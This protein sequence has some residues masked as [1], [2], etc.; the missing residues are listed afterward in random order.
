MHSLSQFERKLPEAKPAMASAD[1]TQHEDNPGSDC[2]PCHRD[3]PPIAPHISHDWA[4][5]LY[6]K[7]QPQ[8]PL[9][10]EGL[11]L[12]VWWYKSRH[13]NGN[14]NAIAQKTQM[15]S[16]HGPLVPEPVARGHEPKHHQGKLLG[17][18]C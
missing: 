6:T 5:Q 16:K 2:R 11:L 13:P 15:V 1:W 17:E 3:A 14:L 4:Y 8:H 18:L 10:N 12:G 9:L 7:L